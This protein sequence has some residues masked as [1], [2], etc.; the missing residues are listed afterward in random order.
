[1]PDTPAA[2]PHLVRIAGAPGSGK[3][4]LTTALTEAF[5][6][7]GV[8]TASAT[9]RPDG[10]TVFVLSNSGRATLDRPLT[11]DELPRLLRSL[12]PSARLLLAEGYPAPDD[13]LL[14]PTVEV[15]MWGVGPATPA[16]ALVSSVDGAALLRQFQHT[17][18]KDAG[19]AAEVASAIQRRV[20]GEAP[21]TRPRS[22]MGEWGWGV[23]AKIRR[24]LGR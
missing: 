5:R 14:P 16:A 18:P 1:M 23:T 10:A 6:T 21:G 9:R 22:K 11:L 24:L 17:G 15:L 20:L 7:R 12:D 19:I 3:S 2:L 13:G 8:R 4:L